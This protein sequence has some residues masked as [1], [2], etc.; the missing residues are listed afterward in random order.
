[1]SHTTY[2]LKLGIVF[3]S[4]MLLMQTA[5]AQPANPREPMRSMQVKSWVGMYLPAGDMADRFGNNALVGLDLS[6]QFKNGWIVGAS[7]GHFFGNQVRERD[8][9][10]NIATPSG[11]IITENG[12]FENYRLRP[13]GWAIYGHVGK[14]LPVFG[15][16]KNSG[17]LIQLGVGVMQHKIWI[18]TPKLASP[19]LAGD[20]KKGYDRLT[21]GLSLNQ[22][23]GYH[24][25]S[26]NKLIN[27]YIGLDLHQGF[28]Q[29]RRTLNYNTGMADTRQRLDL[30]IGLKAGWILPLY[31]RTEKALLYY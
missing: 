6:Y 23:I 13:F 16:N 2:T 22:F 8:I 29:N 27:F 3:L 17:L 12:F 15:P 7:G 21:N 14:I 18:E 26:N 11:D 9:M 1:M 4:G 20:Y 19:Q 30:L 28:T 31:K 10:S 24:H 5:L 25:L